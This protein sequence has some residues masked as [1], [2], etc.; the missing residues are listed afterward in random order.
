MPQSSKRV[1]SCN[2]TPQH[3]NACFSAC[4]ARTAADVFKPK[5]PS[6]PSCPPVHRGRRHERRRKPGVLTASKQ[7][8]VIR[9][10]RLKHYHSSM[11]TGSSAPRP[12]PSGCGPTVRHRSWLNAASAA[13]L[14]NKP[15]SRCGE[16]TVS[17]TL[18]SVFALRG[19]SRCLLA[20][21]APRCALSVLIRRA[22]RA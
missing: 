14:G 10:H 17:T 13:Q 6:W 18:D 21:A 11:A 9:M 22:G 2:L 8:A 20:P 3:A 4:V 7:A 5:R 15:N 19:H 16:N 1:P 12:S